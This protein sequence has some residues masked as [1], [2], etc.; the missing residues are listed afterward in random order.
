MLRFFSCSYF[1]INIKSLPQFLTFLTV[2]KFYKIQNLKSEQE[3]ALNRLIQIL[4]IVNLYFQ[5][6]P[7]VI[8]QFKDVVFDAKMTERTRV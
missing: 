1:V 3:Q 2:E 6:Y 5:F 8:L 4:I 7:S